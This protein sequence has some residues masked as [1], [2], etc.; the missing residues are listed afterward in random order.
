MLREIAEQLEAAAERDPQFWVGLPEEI[1]RARM[2]QGARHQRATQTSGPLL[3]VAVQVAPTTIE[4]A[5]QTSREVES[6]SS[7]SS[8]VGDLESLGME[9]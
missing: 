3:D 2:T 8:S 7:S 5:I 6:S 9:P 1:D 4:R